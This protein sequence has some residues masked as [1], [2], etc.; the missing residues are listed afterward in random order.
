MHD[1]LF[2]HFSFE[3]FF[4]LIDHFTVVCL[5]TW[6]MNEI[7]ARVDLWFDRNLIAFLM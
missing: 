5:V 3:R 1:F 4:F 2:S 7:E 6:P